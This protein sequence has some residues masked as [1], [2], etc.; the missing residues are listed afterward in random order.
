MDEHQLNSKGKPRKRALRPGQ[1]L[2]PNDTYDASP[3]YPLLASEA[4]KRDCGRPRKWK[5]PQEIIDLGIE[6]FERAVATQEPITITGLACYLGTTRET[7]NEYEKGSFSGPNG[8]HPGFTSAIKHVKHV[9]QAYAETHGFHARNPAF[10]IFALKNYGWSDTIR[11]E[12]H[13]SVEHS[14]DP[15]TMSIVQ[16]YLTQLSQ[17]QI[18]NDPVVDVVPMLPEPEEVKVKDRATKVKSSASSK[19]SRKVINPAKGK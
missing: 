6:Y 3:K 15:E 10:A 11:L 8:D 12:Q 14:I 5:D 18:S 2:S 16:G 7:L 4:L 9:A 19:P 1:T 17:A 13:V